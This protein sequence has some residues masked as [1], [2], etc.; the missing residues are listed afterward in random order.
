MYDAV[1][2]RLDCKGIP[3]TIHTLEAAYFRQKLIIP[4]RRIA[5][6]FLICE[7][8]LSCCTCASCLYQIAQLLG[9]R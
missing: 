4:F 7:Y 6:D 1:S 5:I 9:I 3:F 8:A 2:V